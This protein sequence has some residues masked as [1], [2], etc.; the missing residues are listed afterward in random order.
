LKPTLDC[1]IGKIAEFGVHAML[2]I[3]CG[4]PDIKIDVGV[5]EKRSFDCDL[6]YNN[7]GEM[8]LSGI[9]VKSTSTPRNLSWIV[10]RSN[11]FSTGGYD[12]TILDADG[13]TAFTYVCG[14]IVDL[15]AIC[16]NSWLRN[17]GLFKEP[18]RK[19]KKGIKSAIY[20]S[21]MLEAT[22]N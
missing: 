11:N 6:P 7:A 8:G 17:K 4:Y 12:G 16:P 13:I 9:G 14:N 3:A 19:D 5:Y 18:Y 10:N 15:K 22:G 1:S 21:D 20:F 2:M